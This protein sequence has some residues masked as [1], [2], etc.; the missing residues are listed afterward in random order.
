MS[1]VF[2]VDGKWIVQLF[3]STVLKT[4]NVYKLDWVGEEDLVDGGLTVAVVN[5]HAVKSIWMVYIRGKRNYPFQQL[6]QWYKL[7]LGVL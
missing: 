7:R 5:L 3:F 4:S 2:V 1:A 6:F